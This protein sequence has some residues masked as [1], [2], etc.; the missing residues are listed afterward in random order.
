M[1]MFIDV[2]ERSLTGKLCPERKFDLKIFS[3]KLREVV[4]EYDIKYDPKT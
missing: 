2:I 4:K 1:I 3:A